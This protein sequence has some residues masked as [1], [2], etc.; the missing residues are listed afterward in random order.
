MRADIEKERRSSLIGPAT[1]DVYPPGY[2][3]LEIDFGY[4]RMK[5]GRANPLWTHSE[6]RRNISIR[7]DLYD[8][9]I[10]KIKLYL[11][12]YALAFGL[13]SYPLL[14]MFS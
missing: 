12:R 13:R 6:H 5:F 11:V 7:I 2:P 8:L 1:F 10:E 4:I 9:D 3:R 14:L